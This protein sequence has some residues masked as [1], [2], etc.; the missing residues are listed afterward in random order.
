MKKKETLDP[1]FSNGKKRNSNWNSLRA[2]L[3][4]GEE[5]PD[6]RVLHCTWNKNFPHLR[7]P[8]ITCLVPDEDSAD[9]RILYCLPHFRWGFP[10]PM[11]VVVGGGCRICESDL[12][13]FKNE[14]LHWPKSLAIFTIFKCGFSMILGSSRKYLSPKIWLPKVNIRNFNWRKLQGN[15]VISGF[16][17]CRELSRLTNTSCPHNIHTSAA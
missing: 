7:I 6:L 1:F 8:Y 9:L 16:Q 17:A 2:L 14:D 3:G 5:S 10:H 15:L 11:L 4:T 12:W 13:T